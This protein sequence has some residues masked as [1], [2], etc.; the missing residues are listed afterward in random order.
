MELSDVFI[1]RQPILD[2]SMKLFA[3]ELLFRNGKARGADVEDNVQA[4]ANVMVNALSNVGIRRLIG[5][6]KGFINVDE[7]ML[8]SGVTD[9]LPKAGTVLEILETVEITDSFMELCRE[10]KKEGSHFALDDFVYRGE[11]SPLFDIVDYVKVDVLLSDRQAVEDTVRAVKRHKLKLLAEKVETREDFEYLR[12]LGFELFQGY[13]FAR[14]SIITAKSIPPALM[15]LMEVLRLLSQEA[16]LHS[17]EELFRKNP[18]LN[19]KLL[20]FMNSASFYT[21]KVTSI[22][23]SITLLGY[24]KLQKWITLLL[25]AGAGAGEEMGANPLL[26]RAAIR[27]RIAE[28]LAGRIEAD[29]ATSDSAFIAG[30]LSLADALFQMPIDQAV[31]DLNLSKEIEDALVGR[32]GLLG[33]LISITEGL[34]KDKLADTANLLGGFNLTLEDLFLIEK[35]SIL[36]YESYMDE[37]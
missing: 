3:F 37:H 2:R 36:E 10:L 23:Q 15:V 21:H 28:L 13:F 35:T 20:Q 6:R 7:A 29:E 19:F 34:E 25:F 8:R 4:T 16:E 26:E 22:R 32:T 14:P 33:S 1:G 17:I 5:D 27:G 24:R 12:D 30:V 11:A 9:L 18:E 31:R